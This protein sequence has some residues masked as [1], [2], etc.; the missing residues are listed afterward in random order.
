MNL[1][2]S[3][4]SGLRNLNDSTQGRPDRNRANPGLNDAIPLGL[5]DGPLGRI[6]EQAISI[7]L[8]KAKN[9]FVI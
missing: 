1:G 3:T 4:L 9:H 5:K 8:K 6:D 2:Y 7:P